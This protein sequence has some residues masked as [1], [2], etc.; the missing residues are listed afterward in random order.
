M[1]RLLIYAGLFAFGYYVGRKSN[2][3][4]SVRVRTGRERQERKEEHE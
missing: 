3:R 2:R 4:E 1:I